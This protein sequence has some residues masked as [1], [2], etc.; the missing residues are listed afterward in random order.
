MGGKFYEGLYNLIF[1]TGNSFI[2]EEDGELFVES[3]EGISPVNFIIRYTY[4]N[5]GSQ[6]STPP[7]WSYKKFTNDPTPPTGA[8]RHG[9]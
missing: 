8:S 6:R 1:R 5:L 9:I 4:K 2:V 3:E 7:L